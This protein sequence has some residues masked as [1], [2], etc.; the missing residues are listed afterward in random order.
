MTPRILHISRIMHNLSI[1]DCK[2]SKFLKPESLSL[3][4]KLYLN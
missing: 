1:E 3:K 4:L 2:I